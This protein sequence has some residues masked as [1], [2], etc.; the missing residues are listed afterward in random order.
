[1]AEELE[2]SG[3]GAER[4]DPK[5]TA[6]LDVSFRNTW[7][8]KERTSSE[9]CSV[10]FSVCTGFGFHSQCCWEIRKRGR[11]GCLSKNK[12]KLACNSMPSITALENLTTC[13]TK[14]D[15]VFQF[16]STF[17]NTP[18][19]CHSEASPCQTVEERNNWREM[20]V[21]IDPWLETVESRE[22]WSHSGE[23]HWDRICS[24]TRGSPSKHVGR[25]G[26][27]EV[28]LIRYGHDSEE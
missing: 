10:S 20:V 4:S 1:M 13:N 19:H 5:E 18:Q 2:L 7:S 11:T 9:C 3:M 6:T 12:E 15:G 21:L 8:S 26:F 16:P 28:L 23:Q 27:A 14:G 25:R 17:R 24:W 22:K